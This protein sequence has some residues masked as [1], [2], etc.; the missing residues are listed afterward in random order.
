MFIDDWLAAQPHRATEKQKENARDKA[1][2]IKQRI[3][4]KNPEPRRDCENR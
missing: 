4:C 2:D 1:T 3:G